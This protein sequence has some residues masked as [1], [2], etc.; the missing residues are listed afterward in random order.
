MR[1]PS[2]PSSVTVASIA[3]GSMSPMTTRMPAARKRRAS[4]RPMPLPPPVT[5]HTLSV[6][7][8][9]NPPP[10]HDA[11]SWQGRCLNARKGRRARTAWPCRDSRRAGIVPALSYGQSTYGRTRR[12]RREGRTR[13][14]RHPEPPREAQRRQLR[15]DVPPLRRLEAA[16][17][18]RRAAR[19]HPHRQGRHLLRGH[20][21]LGDRKARSGASRTTSGWSG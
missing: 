11:G 7:E 1:F 10:P 5:T 14:H 12:H 2:P 3:P 15:G 17:P 19:G 13:P 21:P 20:G 6:S 16:R 18:G 8:S 4:S 9:I